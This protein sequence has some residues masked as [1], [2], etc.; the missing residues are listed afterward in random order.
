MERLSQHQTYT[1]KHPETMKNPQ[2]ALKRIAE[3]ADHLL[4]VAEFHPDYTTTGAAIR[5][6]MNFGCQGVA[7]VLAGIPGVTITDDRIRGMRLK[8][9]SQPIEPVCALTTFITTNCTAGGSI[10]FK[11]FA[12]RF[13]GPVDNRNLAK[14]LRTIPGLEVRAGGRN[15]LKIYGIQWAGNPPI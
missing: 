1:R 4:E 12:E 8:T 11:E 14:W 5:A 9:V 10:V 15:V 7:H 6:S 2:T 13:N 3:I